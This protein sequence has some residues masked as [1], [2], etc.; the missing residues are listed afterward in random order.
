MLE[1][2]FFKLYF[3]NQTIEKVIN[4]F[5]MERLNSESHQEKIKFHQCH[6]MMRFNGRHAFKFLLMLLRHNLRMV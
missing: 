2:T 4:I 3:M 6:F 1:K 5:L